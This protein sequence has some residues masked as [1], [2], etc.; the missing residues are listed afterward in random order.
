M[1]EKEVA[2]AVAKA[3][4]QIKSGVATAEFKKAVD[5]ELQVFD[6]KNRVTDWMQPGETR[7]NPSRQEILFGPGQSASGFGADRM[8]GEYSDLTPQ[9]GIVNLYGEFSR[10]LAEIKTMK[11]TIELITESVFSMAKAAEDTKPAK[12]TT[13]EDGVK[14]EMV[15]KSR[16][17]L[18]KSRILISKAEDSDMEGGEGDDTAIEEVD[19]DIDKAER[20][21]VKAKRFLTKADD[22]K[23]EDED[24]DGEDDREIEKCRKLFKGLTKRLADVK[25]TVQAV[26]AKA[27]VVKTDVEPDVKPVDKPVDK[28]EKTAEELEEEAA[29]ANQLPTEQATAKGAIVIN[30][31]TLDTYF[32]AVLGG[33]S[34]KT[35]PTLAKSSGVDVLTR[36][37]MDVEQAVDDGILTPNDSIQSQSI[38]NAIRAGA[39]V[40]NVH[41]LIKNSSRGLQD[42]FKSSIVL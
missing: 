31:G 3:L 11:S 7:I 1:T 29:K 12:D 25:E 34:V 20:H 8:I 16:A 26:K 17:F 9:Q 27:K 30:N 15:E 33:G 22:A 6:P 10:M 28:T 39:P 13:D 32:N 5:D 42:A 38:V 41:A 21:L 23:A 4:H 18:K 19:N 37:E 35:G 24:D 14:D 2:A 40:Q 36:I